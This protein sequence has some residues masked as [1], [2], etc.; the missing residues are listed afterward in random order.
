MSQYL[1]RVYI[2]PDQ[3]LIVNQPT[4]Y[5]QVMTFVEL[6]N[7]DGTPFE[8]VQ[9]DDLE[10]TADAQITYSQGDLQVSGISLGF[11][12]GA[13]PVTA[14]SKWQG[15]ADEETWTDLSTA[16]VTDSEQAVTPY[17]LTNSDYNTFIRLYSEATDSASTPVTVNGNSQSTEITSDPIIITTQTKYG[18]GEFV[19]SSI[20]V[21]DTCTVIPAVAEGGLAPLTYTTRI[22]RDQPAGSA[23]GWQTEVTS[24][25]VAN[26][27]SYTMTSADAMHKFQFQTIVKDAI[28][29][30]KNSNKTSPAVIQPT[31][32]GTVAITPANAEV[33]LSEGNGLIQLDVSLEGGTS[34]NWMPL[35]SIR[36]GS[37]QIESANNYSETVVIKV[38]G[39]A[40]ETVQVQCDVSDTIASNSPQSSV[41]TLLIRI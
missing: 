21:G 29:Q 37:A 3:N 14:S 13:A 7:P 9:V 16:E 12:G 38:T 6:L 27:A 11:I 36:S 25:D 10:V 23:Q 8:P 24:T 32:L 17:T 30:S 2:D 20:V 28:N 39:A 19:N 5:Q 1:Q 15:S 26:P 35:W 40:G 31:E 18:D 4:Q 33:S 22:R 34:T 41:A